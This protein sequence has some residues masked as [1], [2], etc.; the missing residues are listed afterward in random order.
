MACNMERGWVGLL[1]HDLDEIR[2]LAEADHP[3]RALPDPRFDPY[4]LVA[5]LR[6]GAKGWKP[7][8]ASFARHRLARLRAWASAAEEPAALPSAP[9]GPQVAC[10]ACGACFVTAAALAAH[11][12]RLHGHRSPL[13]Q[14]VASTMCPACMREF[15]TEERAFHHLE[16][17]VACRQVIPRLVSPLTKEQ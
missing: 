16:R 2:S 15:W 5:Y 8:L 10:Q 1:M 9:E 7:L 4:P 13:R 12:A 11:A 6:A 17:A 3:Y 14:F